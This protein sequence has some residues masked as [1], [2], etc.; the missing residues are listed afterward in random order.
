MAGPTYVKALF[1]AALPTLLVCAIWAV[2]N[3]V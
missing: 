2:A 1:V 3:F